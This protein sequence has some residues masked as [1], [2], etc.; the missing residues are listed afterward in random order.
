[1]VDY[2]LRTGELDLNPLIQ[3]HIIDIRTRWQDENTHFWTTV[4]T[5]GRSSINSHNQGYKIEPLK[6][7]TNSK[8]IPHKSSESSM[9][10]DH[11]THPREHRNINTLDPP[12]EIHI[13]NKNTRNYI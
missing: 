3:P 5:Q 2:I 13:P 12:L 10:S 4:N 9:L 8:Y 11:P 1:M 7:F 6:Y